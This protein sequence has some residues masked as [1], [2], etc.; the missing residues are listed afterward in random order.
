MIGGNIKAK[1]ELLNAP[2]RDITAPK[3]GTAAARANVNTTN[4]VRVRYSPTISAVSLV[5]CRFTNGQ[6]MLKGT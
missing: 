6:T 4:K 1:A 2:T 3:F 5:R